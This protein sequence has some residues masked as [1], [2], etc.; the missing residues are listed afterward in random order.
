MGSCK[1]KV[2]EL[3]QAFLSLG[4]LNLHLGSWLAIL[5]SDS[6]LYHFFLVPRAEKASF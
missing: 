3:S 6:H 1:I 5:P 4:L 2:P